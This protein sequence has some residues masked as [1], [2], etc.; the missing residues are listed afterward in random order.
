MMPMRAPTGPP[1]S[2]VRHRGRQ[3]ITGPTLRFRRH[4]RRFHW[5]LINYS[6]II[7]IIVVVVVL[8]REG[9]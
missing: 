9:T 3:R 5:R 8:A 1:L 6:P 4:P 2:P 7:V